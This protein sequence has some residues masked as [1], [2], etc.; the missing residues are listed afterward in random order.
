MDNLTHSLVGLAAA[1][2]GLERGSPYATAVCVVA[3]NLPDGDIVMRAAGSWVYLKHHRGLTHSVVGTLALAVL[4]PL[5]VYAAERLWS[6][7]RGR[8]PRARLG[9]LL[10]AS[11]V[12]SATHPLLDWTNSYGV[13]PLLPWDSTW[14]YGDL[15]FILDPWL[16]LSL[17]GAC[18]LLTATTRRRTFAWASLALVLTAAILLLPGRGGMQYPLVSRALWLLGIAGLFVA[19]RAR[20]GARLGSPVAAVAL[21]L[22]VV[23]WG[24]L[25]VLH[26]AAVTSAHAAFSDNM[27]RGGEGFVR[28]AAMPTLADPTR[29]TCV[30]ETQR[31][32]IRFQVTLF[33]R[34][35][36][37]VQR[38]EKS[39][40]A[41]EAAAR[42]ASSD[43][44]AA[45]FL[46]FARFPASRLTRD[47][48]GQT[49]LQFADLRFALP[50]A[51][52]GNFTLEL[53]VAETD[54]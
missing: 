19:H 46:D 5:A 32:F 51:R 30:V 36:R 38:V 31:D 15:V 43:Y 12:A 8:A 33:D 1:K 50:G 35:P 40:A 29:W 39:Q 6:R 28:V 17:G 26:A 14:F 7:L 27:L 48:A 47:C 9:G 18:F 24:A 42:A 22:V 34:A 53:P 20:L 37:D 25:A 44:A 45:V 21:A 4:L 52:R 3:A 13:R 41:A 10:V 11:L 49:L 16:W 54:E 23:Y 2:A